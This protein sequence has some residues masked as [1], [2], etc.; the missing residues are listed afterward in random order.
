[1]LWPLSRRGVGRKR[2]LGSR[3]LDPPVD[4]VR[5]SPRIRRHDL[6]DVDPDVVHGRQVVDAIPAGNPSATSA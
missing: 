6:G 1:M 4:A 5:A 2:L 3:T